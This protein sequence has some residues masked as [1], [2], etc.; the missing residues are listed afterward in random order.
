MLRALAT[1]VFTSFAA[2]QGWV[3]RTPANPLQTPSPRAFPAMCWDTAHGYVL[4]CGGQPNPYGGGGSTN[5]TWTWNGTT[6]TR[7]LTATPGLAPSWDAPSIA[8]MAFHPPTNQAVLLYGGGTSVWNGTD[9]LQHPSTLPMPSVPWNGSPCNVAMGYDP[10]SGQLVAFVGSLWSSQTYYHVAYTFT[11]DG[12]SWTRRLTATNPWPVMYPTM[13]FDP[14]ANRLVLGTQGGTGGAFFEWTG[15][16]WQQRLPAGAP[17]ATGTFAT[18]T[19]NNRLVMFDGDLGLQPGHTWTLANGALQQFVPP[20][21]PGRRFGA[22]MAYD[23][24]RQRIVLFG[25]T[26]NWAPSQPLQS[27]FLGDTWELALPAGAS[28]TPFGVGCAGSRGVPTLTASGGSLPHAGQLFQATVTN[29]PFTAPAF[30]FLGLSNTGYGGLPLP[31]NLGFL[32][33]PA[34]SLLVSGDD[35]SLVTNVLGTGHWQWTIPNVPG[36]VFYNQAFVFDAA[37]NPLGITTSNG[38]HATI[39]F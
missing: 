11:W 37:A 9:W 25:G 2:A 8:A 38:A 4:L 7:R 17:S 19:A 34:C 31:L 32:G 24:V 6:W 3:D 5:E 20:L 33:A 12:T 27:N 35:V 18:D 1:A 28:Y 23:P 14:V 29:L 21:E 22:A 39:G 13:A 16:N 36:A 30:L 10:A 26:A 15:S